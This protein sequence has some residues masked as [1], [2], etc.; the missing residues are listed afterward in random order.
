MD[1][2]IVRGT[3][4]RRKLK[5]RGE[6]LSLDDETEGPLIRTLLNS[7]KAVASDSDE[8]RKMATAIA[9]EPDPGEGAERATADPGSGEG[10]ESTSA[11]RARSSRGK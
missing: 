10:A 1:L 4:I 2:L 6:S 11:Q 9:A 5:K 7:R 3:Y 8:G